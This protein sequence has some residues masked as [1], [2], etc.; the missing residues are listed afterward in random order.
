MVS[1]SVSGIEWTVDSRP[2]ILILHSPNHFPHIAQKGCRGQ[3]AAR[4]QDVDTFPE[5]LKGLPPDVLLRSLKQ[6]FRRG[7]IADKGH[8]IPQDLFHPRNF[9]FRIE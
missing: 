5:G 8:F 7:N 3:T 4:G 1:R 6:G 9:H 2:N